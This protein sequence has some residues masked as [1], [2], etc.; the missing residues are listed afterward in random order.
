MKPEQLSQKLINY[1]HEITEIQVDRTTSL[2]D[3]YIIDSFSMLNLVTFLENLLG[4]KIR[5]N[6]FSSDNFHSVEVIEHW[7]LAIVERDKS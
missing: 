3:E 1:I 2:L 6:D 7:A 4:I 5:P